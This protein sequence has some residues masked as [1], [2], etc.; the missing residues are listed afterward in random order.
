M[1]SKTLLAIPLFTLVLAHPTKAQ[2][3]TLNPGSAI[4]VA[5]KQRF[6]SQRMGKDFVFRFLNK[7][8]EAATREMQT[9]MISFEENQKALKAY[10][11][12]SIMPLVAREEAL[13]KDY[14]KILQGEPT[15]ENVQAIVNSN[16]QLLAASNDIVVAL[17]KWAATQ[18]RK[19]SETGITADMVVE[20]TN[21]SGRMRMLS[22]RLSLYYGAYVG[23]VNTPNNDIVK[24]IQQVATGIQQGISTLVTSEANT[25][26]IDDA[27]STAVIDW[28]GIEEKCSVNNCLSF[29]EKSMDPADVFNVTNRF[30]IKMDKITGMYARLLN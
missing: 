13:Y 14:K 4:N 27:I 21:Q 18:P 30:L 11:P 16:S 5:G 15:K 28:R 19:E 20:N 6:L 9:S 26:E 23:G 29:E 7:N 10:V 2:T 17:I 8:V 1:Y 22:Q 3:S 25:V 12:Q 24:Q